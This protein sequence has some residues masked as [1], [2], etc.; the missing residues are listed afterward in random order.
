MSKKMKSEERDL[1]TLTTLNNPI[2][3]QVLQGLLEEQGIDFLMELS[4]SSALSE[5]FSP[6]KG[7][8]RVRV[9]KGDLDRAKEILADLESS[10]EVAGSAAMAAEVAK[11]DAGED[12]PD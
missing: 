12:L 10:E 6:Q 7:Y 1:I 4:E 2:E 5:I 8:A 3:A 11:T 9:F